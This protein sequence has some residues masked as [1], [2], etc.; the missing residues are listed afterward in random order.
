MK[1]VLFPY[2]G[3]GKHSYK[4]ITSFFY[5]ECEYLTVE[6]RGRGDKSK[7]PF[8]ADFEF[9][10]K[11]LKKEVEQFI[12]KDDDIVF[13]GHSLGAYLAWEVAKMFLLE[14]IKIRKVVL[15]GIAPFKYM[16]N[17]F[18]F[19]TKKELLFFFE[20]IGG[21]PK[22]EKYR[23]E[24]LDYIYPLLKMDL[25]LL[26]NYIT[27]IE[28]RKEEVMDINLTVLYGD[29]D[30]LYSQEDVYKWQEFVFN[31]VQFYKLNGNH[32]FINNNAH[33]VADKIIK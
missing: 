23:E 12:L 24:L 16:K 3:G 19:T 31:K 32:F 7:K 20:S 10:T 15:S 30:I 29:Q 27:V 11:E 8:C 4:K 13:Y 33:F 21:I 5:P 9:V 25:E 6:L 1:I 2:S 28:N 14:G 17:T 26:K 22:I 18:F